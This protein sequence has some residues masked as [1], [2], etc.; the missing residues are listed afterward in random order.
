MSK[1][2]SKPSK[3][4]CPKCKSSDNVVRNGFASSKKQLWRCKACK[5]GFFQ[6][7]TQRKPKF[8]YFDLKILCV[9]LYFVGVKVEDIFS[10]V[11]QTPDN[12]MV[13]EQ[14]IYHWLKRFDDFKTKSKIKVKYEIMIANSNDEVQPIFM[15]FYNLF[16]NYPIQSYLIHLGLNDRTREGASID[17]MTNSKEAPV[18]LT[19]N[20]TPFWFKLLLFAF[21]LNDNYEIMLRRIFNLQNADYI[22]QLKQLFENDKNVLDYKYKKYFQKIKKNE[23][24]EME[25]TFRG[26]SKSVRHIFI[27]FDALFNN[28]NL[29]IVERREVYKVLGQS[30][31]K[32]D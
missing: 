18:C 31:K 16:Q 6:K 12:K 24:L 21:M 28:L 26:K 14:V 8:E 32:I 10:H 9:F 29:C 25:G 4:N 3:P 23:H 7:K 11:V 20:Q 30:Q 22:S 13:S 27:S 19:V 15:K 2:S 17:I 1:K 5:C